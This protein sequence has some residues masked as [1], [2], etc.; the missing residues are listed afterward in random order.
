MFLAF[1]QV[2]LNQKGTVRKILGT[3]NFYTFSLTLFLLLILCKS[4]D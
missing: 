3:I 1:E 4:G 2:P